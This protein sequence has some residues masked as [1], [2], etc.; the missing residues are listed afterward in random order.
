MSKWSKR[1]LYTVLAA[2]GFYFLVIFIF[3]PI[4]ARL[5]KP[6]KWKTLPFGQSRQLVHNYL[7]TPDSIGLRDVWFVTRGNGKYRLEVY[8]NGFTQADG[9]RLF[10][11]YDKDIFRD[12]YL[13]ESSFVSENK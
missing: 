9:Y 4:G 5:N 7:G 8:Y 13:I 1:V 12:Y 3:M 11:S 2:I 6:Y 10:F